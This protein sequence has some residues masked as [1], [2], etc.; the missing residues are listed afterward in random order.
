[1]ANEVVSLLRRSLIVLCGPAGSGK[2]TFVSS[3]VQHNHLTPTAVVSSDACRLML[4]DETRSL[5]QEQWAILQPNTFQLFLAIIGMRM[6]IGRPTIADGVNLHRE[7]RTGML[8]LA[9][10]HEYPTALVVFDMPLEACLTQNVQREESRRIPEWQIEAQRKALDEA[11][12]R[13]S[14]EGW[15]QVIVLN[16]Q[17]RTVLLDLG[18]KDDIA[19]GNDREPR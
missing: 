4:C 8:D 6:N 2:S 14:D 10:K 16:E 7:L 3:I 1:M 12:P 17:R 9:R 11:M 13:L 5:T 18:N 19:R 15:N